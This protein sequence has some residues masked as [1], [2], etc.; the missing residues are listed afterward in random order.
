MGLGNF[1]PRILAFS[2][3]NTLI[4]LL[5][6]AACFYVYCRVRS[7]IALFIGMA[8]LIKVISS[9]IIPYLALFLG[10]HIHVVFSEY[11]WHLI[12]TTLSNAIFAALIM[13]G[14]LKL[15]G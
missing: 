8:F 10:Y 7:K 6:I 3:I 14:V 5:I 9:I 13:L 11:S 12:L 15:A 4:E 1:D 2:L